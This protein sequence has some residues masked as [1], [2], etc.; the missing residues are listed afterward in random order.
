MEIAENGHEPDMPIR[1][2][3]RQPRRRVQQ[4]EGETYR[5]HPA[6]APDMT[7]VVIPVPAHETARA[8]QKTTA[9]GFAYSRVGCFRPTALS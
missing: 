9:A 1:P 5:Q 4:C 3:R 7:T 8:D 2:V 6:S